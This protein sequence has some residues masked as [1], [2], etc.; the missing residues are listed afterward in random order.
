MVKIK[1]SSRAFY[2][3]NIPLHTEAAITSIL[4]TLNIL[5]LCPRCII[6]TALYINVVYLSAFETERTESELCRFAGV[7]FSLVSILFIEPNDKKEDNRL[8]L[9]HA[10]SRFREAG[11]MASRA[12]YVQN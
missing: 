1:L 6:I 11:N 2:T 9:L 3:L 4:V 10:T 5:T 8:C 7:I 12:F